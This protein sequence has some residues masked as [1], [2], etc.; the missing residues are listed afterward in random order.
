MEV[1]F[2]LNEKENDSLQSMIRKSKS[3]FIEIENKEVFFNI[4]E[5]NNIS[6]PHKVPPA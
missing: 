4:N 3:A 1:E 5:L 2:G 6:P